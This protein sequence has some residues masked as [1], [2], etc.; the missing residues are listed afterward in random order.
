MKNTKTKTVLAGALVLTV[1]L[2]GF[3][4]AGKAGDQ[5]VGWR[6]RAT[7][8]ECQTGTQYRINSEAVR[9]TLRDHIVAQVQ[10]ALR[11][12]GYYKGEITGFMGD[13]TQRAI[14]LFQVCHCFAAAPLINRCVLAALGIGS[15]GKAVFSGRSSGQRFYPA[16]D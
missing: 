7:S 8:L 11:Q 9:L 16:I 4:V 10:L 12:R 1:A 13:E 2:A 3:P 6:S 5:P 14:Q 15:E